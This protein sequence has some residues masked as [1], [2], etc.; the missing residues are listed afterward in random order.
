MAIPARGG[1]KRLQRKNL[2]NIGGKPLIAYTI[3]AALKSK[4]SEDVFVCTEDDEIAE[5][6]EKYGAKVFMLPDEMVGDLISSTIPCLFLLEN[7]VSHGKKIEY[8]FNLQPTSPL[9]QSEDII[10]SLQIIKDSNADYLLSVTKIDPHY[11]HWALKPNNEEWGMYFGKEYLI[12]RPLLPDVYRPNGAIKLARAE[13]ILKENSFFGKNLS[14]YEMPEEK[15][16]HVASLFDI[17]CVEG[18]L[19]SQ[20]Q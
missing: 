17:H 9:R 6:G 10:K 2:Y 13:K 7:L 16:I 14:V 11:F 4:L 8:L 18:I 3:E 15:S 5:V 1:S 19:N 12:E 20:N